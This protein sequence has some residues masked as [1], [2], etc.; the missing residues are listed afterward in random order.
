[1]KVKV[2]EGEMMAWCEVTSLRQRG[3]DEVVM[4]GSLCLKD[5]LSTSR[6]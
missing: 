4:A 3:R 2:R 5:I 6:V 1:M